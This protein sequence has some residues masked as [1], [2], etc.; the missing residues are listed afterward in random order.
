MTLVIRDRMHRTT[1]KRPRLLFVYALSGNWDRHLEAVGASPQ[2][3]NPTVKRLGS[4]NLHH[5]ESL[6]VARGSVP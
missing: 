6:A 2:F 5:Q 3:H 4:V 1:A